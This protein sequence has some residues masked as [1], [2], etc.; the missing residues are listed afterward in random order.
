[1]HIYLQSYSFNFVAQQVSTNNYIYHLISYVTENIR[2][3]TLTV[4]TNILFEQNSM[5]IQ[6]HA[7]CYSNHRLGGVHA[8]LSEFSAADLLPIQV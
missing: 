7:G 1:M 8:S 3:V 2:C 6:T 5:L 4:I